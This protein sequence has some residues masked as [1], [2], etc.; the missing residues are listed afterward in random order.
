MLLFLAF[1]DNEEP[2]SVNTG[3]R[4]SSVDPHMTVWFSGRSAIT[5]R[6]W[7]ADEQRWFSFIMNQLKNVLHW[8]GFTPGTSRDWTLKTES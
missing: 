5:L 3:G 1:G 6:R 8:Q 4:L 2:C 7:G